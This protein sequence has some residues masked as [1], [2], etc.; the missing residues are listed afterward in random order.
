MLVQRQGGAEEKTLSQTGLAAA[1][2]VFSRFA[3]I[4]G[5]TIQAVLV[6]HS[7]LHLINFFPEPGLRLILASDF[8]AARK[9]PKKA[10]RTRVQHKE[11]RR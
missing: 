11:W 3:A 5:I 2:R 10:A 1:D 6:G 8:S 9:E 4:R 7:L